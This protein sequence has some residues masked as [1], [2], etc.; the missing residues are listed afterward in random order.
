MKN[1]KRFSVALM[2]LWTALESCPAQIG[3]SGASGGPNSAS[4]QQVQAADLLGKRGQQKV[5]LFTGS[6]GYSIPIA[7]APAR[8]GSEPNLA[9]GYSSA[10]ENGW[11]GMGWKLE[12]GSIERNTRDGIPIA[13]STANPPA[14]LTQYDDSKGFMLNLLGKGYKLFSVATNSSVVEYRAETDTEFLRC[15]LDTSN[16][17]WTVYD[18]SGNAYYFGEVAG[19]RMANP[20]TGWSGYSGTFHWALDQIVTAT[21]DW[22]AIV[23]TNYTSPFTGLP[24]RTLYP[25]QIAYN[26]HTN[27][28]GYSANVAGPDKIIFQTEVRTNDWHFSFRSGFRAEQA[29]RLTNILCQ[30]GSQNVWSYNLKY[31]ISPA[32]SRSL[33]T[34]VVVYG[35]DAGNNASAFLTNTFAYQANPNGVSFGST[36]MWTNM[37][38]NTPGTSSGSYEPEVAEIND[39]GQFSYTVADLVDMDGDGLPD[40][41]SYDNSTSPCQ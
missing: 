17:K 22:T 19:S 16:N 13:Y 28:N 3:N 11:C 39:E 31:G 18:K 38:L 5:D 9:L 33:L 32:T 40:R 6:F 21:G 12:I 10:E 1:M 37:I 20:K 15:F 35:F 30:A 4:D 7:C 25:A 8:N 27:F 29:R 23:Y 34:N 36:I 41:V 26:G 14:P 24:E 2:V